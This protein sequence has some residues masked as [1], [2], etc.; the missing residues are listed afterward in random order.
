MST[1]ITEE[2]RH[3]FQA[4][5]S[6]QYHNFALFSCFVVV[7]RGKLTPYWSAPLDPDR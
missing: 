2:H 3:A 4:R 6:G 7:K 5:T 1:N